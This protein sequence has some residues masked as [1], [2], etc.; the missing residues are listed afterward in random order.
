MQ[1]QLH[2][3]KI[4]S[5]QW[6]R[7]LFFIGIFLLSGLKVSAQDYFYYYK[8]EKKSLQLNTEYV[9]VVSEDNKEKAS[10]FR[11]GLKSTPV[12]SKYQLDNTA[13]KL[14]QV[15]GA[16]S[17]NGYWAE[18]KIAEKMQSKAYS[19]YLTFLKSSPSIQ[20]AAPYF[21]TD[22]KDK[23][24]LSQ[25]FYVKL[26]N[27]GDLKV[28]QK[29]A[30]ERK[31]TIVGQN[32]FMPKW[33]TLQCDKNSVGNALDNANFFFE[34]RNFEVA[35]PDLMADYFEQSPNDPLYS[36]QWGMQNT[37]QYGGTVGIDV[38]A[39]EAWDITTGSRDVVVAVL[40]HGFEMNHPDLAGNTF[41]TG[42]DT[43]SGTSPSQV[44]GSHGTACAGIVSATQDNN[45]GVSGIAPNAQLMSISNALFLSPTINQE[46][47]DGINWA[48][49]NG[50]EVISNSWGHNS[51]ASALI[52]NAISNALNSGR[53]G[54]GTIVVFAAGNNNGSVIYPASS[55]SDIITVG[56]MSQCAERKSFTSCDGEGWG[57]NY[58]PEL[59]IM[60]PGVKISTTDRQGGNGYSLTDYTA[61]FNGTSSACPMVAGV[62]ALILSVNPCLTHDEV[63]DIIE[64]SAQKVG[65]YT[66]TATG[67]RPNG[68]WN[69][70]MGYGLVD[71]EA[72]VIQ[73]QSMLPNTPSFDLYS[74]DRW[75]DTGA[76]PNPDTGPMWI[77]EDIWVRQ[78][79]DGGTTHQNPE[80]KMFSPN[81]VYIKI[82]NNSSIVSNCANLALYYSK[83]STGLHWPNHWNN[84]SISGTDHGD[85]INTVLIPPILPGGSYTV[86]VPWYPPNPADFSVDIHHF[87][88]LARI[89]SPADPM[90]NE[91][92]NV[93]VSG[94]VRRNNNIVWKNVSVYDNDIS[95]EAGTGL[96]VR[97][98]GRSWEY[99][100]LFF[101]DRGF[102]DRIR[103]PFFDRG[104]QILV[105][106]EPEFYE[107]LKAA[108]IEGIKEIDSKHML[109]TNRE[110]SIRNLKLHPKITHALRFSFNVE[111]DAKETVLLDVIQ[112]DTKTGEFEGGERFL[113]T[114]GN[115]GVKG[116]LM[117]EKP[118]PIAYPNPARESV[119]LN[120][121]VL[122]K[123]ADI[124]VK[125]IDI[126]DRNNERVI[127]STK[128][129][130]GSYHPTISLKGVKKGVYL[131]IIQI[132]GK[133]T[134]E[135]LI[136]E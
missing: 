21:T 118:S 10:A 18:L 68:D 33:Y 27:E 48:W 103:K 23:I 59:D 36:D 7:M 3:A 51:L 80:F 86:E 15:E 108:K 101:F 97:G 78:N 28:L 56:A 38:R 124:S 61:S 77:S 19:G 66:Y 121:E 37:G 126:I 117:E 84:Y 73:A 130:T 110:A 58:G 34:S 120:L 72:A 57:S 93:G 8:G 65:S 79:L 14:K 127:L 131:I 125:L 91:Q 17:S 134:S 2:V 35:E 105:Q 24:A 111:M 114:Q 85:L 135:R 63:E 11:N 5:D 39:E 1:L 99:A 113:I 75:Y 55:N 29:M 83:A 50:A 70:E 87:C 9:Y 32:K 4:K 104:G 31:V 74:R 109:I 119:T 71:A 107:V 96:F 13:A 20:Y 90:F 129:Q 116:N 98:N 128:K 102:K 22:G 106:Y 52:D 12:L 64:M 136:V 82:R 62:A 6:Q 16:K 133:V 60:A 89:V 54:L 95:N 47:A 100:D 67:G 132:N 30:Q 122:D 53:G 26:I 92:L 76:E 25:Y 41:G 43:G 69:N 123:E 45:T 81:G 42:F 49:L 112:A 88:L 46:L 115:R 40:D 94:N 44:L